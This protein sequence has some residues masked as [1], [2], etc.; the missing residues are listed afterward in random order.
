MAQS[1]GCG[2]YSDLQIARALPKD[3]FERYL[4]ARMRL[5]EQDLSAK[6]ETESQAKLRAEVRPDVAFT[7]AHCTARPTIQ[8]VLASGAMN[9]HVNMKQRTPVRIRMAMS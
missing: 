2:C 3:A 1:D 6:L 7:P 9:M 5:A 8:T 4:S